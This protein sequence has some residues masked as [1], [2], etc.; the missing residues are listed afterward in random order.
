MTLIFISNIIFVA[1]VIL[2]MNRMLRAASLYNWNPGDPVVQNPQR[3]KILQ[4]IVVIACIGLVAAIVN[5][6]FS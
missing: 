1:V 4:S 3:I 6:L 2:F 5:A